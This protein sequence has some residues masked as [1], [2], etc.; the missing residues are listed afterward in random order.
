MTT[1]SYGHK[2]RCFLTAKANSF[3]NS[4]CSDYMVIKNLQDLVTP[5]T[6]GAR[7]KVLEREKQCHNFKFCTHLALN[8]SGV[9]LNLAVYCNH[10]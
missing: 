1:V 6:Q 7:K 2:A 8:L 3:I 9:H 4:I 10:V 5:N